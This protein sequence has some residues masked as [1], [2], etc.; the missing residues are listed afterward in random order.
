MPPSP[1][2]LWRTFHDRLRRFIRSRVHDEHLTDDLLQDVFARVLP[3]TTT[4]PKSPCSV[5]CPRTHAEDGQ[6]Q[7]HHG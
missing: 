4:G 3:V 2:E 6:T 5:F 1:D 7:C